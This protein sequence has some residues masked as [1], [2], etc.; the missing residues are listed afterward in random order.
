MQDFEQLKQ[1]KAQ[2][3]ADITEALP[4]Y[5]NR[6]N[7]IDERL[8]TYIDDAISGNASHANL[9][10][11]LGIR[12]EMRLMD[13]YDL[14]PE[15]VK[16]SLRAIEGQWANGRHVKGGLRFSTPRGSQ[17]VRL[18]PFQAWLI[19]EIYA[20]KVDVPMERTYHDGDQLLPTEWVRDGEVWDTRRLTQEAH[21]FLTRK[22]GKSRL[23]CTVAAKFS[24]Q[25][26]DEVSWQKV[27]PQ[28]A[29]AASGEEDITEGGDNQGG[30]N[31]NNP[32]SGELE[33]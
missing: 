20:F 13:S 21:W 19:F 10:E 1:I 25:F 27:D 23:G 29:A 14:D 2:C 11:L 33:G 15:R 6:L 31:G 26:S 18:M 30:G 7:S 12:K 16:R 9:M 17:H 3:L 5:V 28:A 24:R 4:D 8:L 32:P 22:S